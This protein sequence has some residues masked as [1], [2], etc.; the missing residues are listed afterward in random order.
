MGLRLDGLLPA[1][2]L[3][4]LVTCALFLG[5]LLHEALGLSS[6]RRPTDS[7]VCLRNYLVAPLAEEWAF[8]ACLAPLWL[9][10]VRSLLL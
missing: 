4:S 5:P 2:V 3:P 1:L 7:L 9:L 6:I 8:R 10:A